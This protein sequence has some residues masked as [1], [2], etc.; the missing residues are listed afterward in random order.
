MIFQEI[1]PRNKIYTTI[2]RVQFWQFF[3]F[4]V[5][6]IAIH[7]LIIQKSI[8]YYLTD[9]KIYHKITVIEY[10]KLGVLL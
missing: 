6:K 8:I 10:K 7:T 3:N 2:A 1:I 9:T 4:I 5:T